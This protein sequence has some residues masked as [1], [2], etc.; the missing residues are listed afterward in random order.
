MPNISAQSRKQCP[1][2]S[3]SLNRSSAGVSPQTRLKKYSAG[4]DAE[5][6]DSS[7]EL[8]VFILTLHLAKRQS[9]AVRDT[10]AD[11]KSTGATKQ[12]LINDLHVPVKSS[13]QAGQNALTYVHQTVIT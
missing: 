4:L 3:S 8:T 12:F 1:R 2:T 9:P 6:C 13:S 5:G 7:W 10:T 11:A